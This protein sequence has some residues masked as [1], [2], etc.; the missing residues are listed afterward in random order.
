[1]SEK[2]PLSLKEILERYGVTLRDT[3][4][5]MVVAPAPKKPKEGKGK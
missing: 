1:M 3:P 5:G 4:S 2:K